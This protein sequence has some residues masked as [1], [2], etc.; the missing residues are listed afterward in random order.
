MVSL[1]SLLRPC[2]SYNQVVQ[3]RG[4]DLFWFRFVFVWQEHI[5]GVVC[6]YR[7]PQESLSWSSFSQGLKM[8]IFRSYPPFFGASQVALAMDLPAVQEMQRQ[9]SIPGSGKSPGAGM[10]NALF[11]TH[12][13]SLD[14]WVSFTQ[15]SQVTFNFSEGWTCSLHLKR[16]MGLFELSGFWFGVFFLFSIIMSS[17]VQTCSMLQPSQAFILH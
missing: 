1:N 13:L 9:L 11:L 16:T 8:I 12:H 7:V 5:M 14:Y 6:L 10:S 2:Y 3:S 15:E 17:C 4:R